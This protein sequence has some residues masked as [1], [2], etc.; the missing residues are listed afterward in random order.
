MQS[1][2]SRPSGKQRQSSRISKEQTPSRLLSLLNLRRHLHVIS[3]PAA[4]LQTAD[5]TV[6]IRIVLISIPEKNDDTFQYQ[7]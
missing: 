6:L 5:R 4:I 2:D 1:D 3:Q 7:A